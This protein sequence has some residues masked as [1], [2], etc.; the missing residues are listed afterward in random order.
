MADAIATSAQ[1]ETRPYGLWSSPITPRG[2][3]HG[4]RLSDAL[5]DSDGQTLVWL[6]GRSDRGVLVCA[7]IDDPAPRDLTS[8][9]SVRAFVGYGGGD[10]TVGH[11]QVY[12]V[13]GGRLYA[14]PLAGGAARPLTPAAGQ[15]AA[16]VLSPD[17]RW[18]LYVWSDE[19]T[20]CLAVVD[21]AGRRWPQKIAE[22]RDFYMQPRWSPSG[23]AIAWVAWD[24]PQMPWDGT[25]LWLAQVECSGDL[26]RAGE[27]RRLAGDTETAIFQPEFAPN[28]GAISYVSDE[29]GWGQLQVQSIADGSV[30]RLTSDEAEYGRPAWAQGIRSYTWL[31]GG[32]IAAMRSQRGFESLQ[33][34]D[35]QTAGQRALGGDASVYSDIQ[36]P[37]AAPGRG[38]V[39]AV[40]S[41]PH[42][43][44][45]IAEFDVS[46]G[47]Q[48]VWARSSGETVPPDQLAR[49]E[50]IAW[51]SYDGGEAQGLFYAPVG[52]R[53]QSPGRPPLIVL[54]HGGPTSQMTAGY[55]PQTQ[56][57]ATRGYAV[58]EVNYR[59]GTGYGRDYMLKLRGN[60][61]V[62]DVEDS[63]SG[64]SWLAEQGRVDPRRRVIMGGSAGGFTVLQTLSTRPG[65]FTAGICMFG[66]S[67]QFTLASDTHKF[68]QR[69]LDLILGPLPEAA[70]IYRER[71]PI[72]HADQISDPLAI[73]QGDIDRVVPRAQSDEVVAS[74]KARGVPHEYHIYAGEGH[75][76][77]K[78]ET[79]DDFYSSVD[80][81]LKQYVV[82]A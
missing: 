19:Q 56:F 81:F 54:V 18:L 38:S 59:G 9:L 29:R 45:R 74:L 70:A 46:T 64:A 21:S 40:V 23:D 57:F 34:I 30:R 31:D 33:L 51:P 69:Y 48:R 77:R 82:F 37:A 3:A 42:L 28:G 68:E 73:F 36:F 6:E 78:S 22:G 63:I 25:E 72:F 20:D 4:V 76:W 53:F 10:F 67:N 8:D 61:G 5:W 13:S 27:Q 50:A 14:Q 44:Q 43:P 32:R 55:H 16:P 26:P 7:R 41:S 66:V 24:F 62:Y 39:T 17:G 79:I 15:A 52:D 75:G 47:R 11:G 35:T 12:F 80:R 60:W 49:P 71:S 1:R 2:L 58:L 65:F